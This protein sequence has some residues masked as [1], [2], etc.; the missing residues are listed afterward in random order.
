MVERSW[1]VMTCLLLV[2]GCTPLSSDDAGGP[3]ADAG[4]G[5]DSGDVDA[6]GGSVDGGGAD[7][8]GAPDAGCPGGG[9]PTTYYADTDMDDFG[10][11]ESSM[12]A[13]SAPGGYVEDSTDCDDTDDEVFPGSH[14]TEVPGDGVDTDCDGNDFC[15][16]L[17]CDGRP[18]VTFFG[19]T[20]ETFLNT[21]TGFTA[22]SAVPVQGAGTDNPFNGPIAGASADIDGD[23]YLDLFTVYYNDSRYCRHYVLW[24]GPLGYSIE[25]STFLD[26][27]G[28]SGPERESGTRDVRIIDLDGDGNL[29]LLLATYWLF[30]E[31]P[32][33]RDTHA[34]VYYGDGSRGFVMRDYPAERAYTID[35]GDIDGDGA[36]ELV[37]GRFDGPGDVRVYWGSASGPAPTS[38]PTV[39]TTEAVSD[40]DVVDLDGDGDLDIVAATY[41]GESD[42]FLYD[43]TA[44]SR[45]AGFSETDGA[46]A[47]ATNAASGRTLH[48]VARDLDGDGCHE[49]LFTGA[50]GVTLWEGT[51]S[52]MECSWPSAAAGSFATADARMTL[53]E[54]LDGDGNPDVVIAAAGSTDVYLGSGSGVSTSSPTSL[55]TGGNAVSVGDFEG[56]GVL[57]LVVGHDGLT[58]FW[59]RV[60]G[61]TYSSARSASLTTMTAGTGPAVGER[62]TTN[63]D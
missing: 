63:D 40:V 16:D 41:T 49:L 35:A 50:G 10:D 47:L 38:T 3:S 24:G 32:T 25:R 15:T 57:D 8:G 6:G 58:V 17:D 53:V 18:D 14:A 28:A 13:C 62:L 46:F 52:G 45:D 2:A 51:R 5:A 21:G 37:I 20:V 56:D 31:T 23:G 30:M 29:D 55:S 42:V 11:P 43:S 19:A 12:T 39:L 48:V 27:D 54:D 26:H 34:A 1:C 44:A 59:G 4:A 9:A 61:T 22:G 33:G 60:G 36:A 7:G